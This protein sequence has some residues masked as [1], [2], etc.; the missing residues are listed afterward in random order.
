MSNTLGERVSGAQT[1]STNL[2]STFQEIDLPSNIEFVEEEPVCSLEIALRLVNAFNEEF[3]GG[4][5][6]HLEAHELT[7]PQGQEHYVTRAYDLIRNKIYEKLGIPAGTKLK[8]LS[9][10]PKTEIIDEMFSEK[11]R[12]TRPNIALLLANRT[13]SS[14]EEIIAMIDDEKDQYSSLFIQTVLEDIRVN[15]NS[16]LR[17]MATRMQIRELLSE[18][19][20]QYSH[21]TSA[22]RQAFQAMINNVLKMLDQKEVEQVIRVIKIQK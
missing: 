6:F 14:I 16:L 13:V 19:Q 12:G 22:R 7:A 8:T 2:Q 21:E 15:L 4:S 10:P 1:I 11:N 5:I 3:T 20:G 17:R 18:S 9:D